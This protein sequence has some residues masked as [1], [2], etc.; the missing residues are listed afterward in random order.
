MMIA[1]SVRENTADGYHPLCSYD[2]PIGDSAKRCPNI[3]SQDKLSAGTSERRA[4]WMRRHEESLGKK[5][6][7]VRELSILIGCTYVVYMEV[8]AS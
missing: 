8:T 4:G 6:G 7:E 2:K 5:E 1:Q 3:E